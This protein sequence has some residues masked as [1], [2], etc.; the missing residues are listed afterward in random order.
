MKRLKKITG[1]AANS[2]WWSEIEE[3]G[4]RGFLARHQAIT[5]PFSYSPTA[6]VWTWR[7]KPVIHVEISHRCY[8]VYEVPESVRIF[9][10]EQ[11]AEDF[12]LRTIRANDDMGMD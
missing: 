3:S 4:H 8:E 10:H 11:D 6:R 5:S 7:G 1:Y 12:Y 2:R 9:K